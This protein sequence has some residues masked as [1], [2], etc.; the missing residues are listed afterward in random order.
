MQNSL[1]L[2]M[3]QTLQNL[4]DQTANLECAESWLQ[5]YDPKEV[6]GN[7]LEYQADCLLL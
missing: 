6:V 3:G 7:V 2:K 5:V 4:L 1:F